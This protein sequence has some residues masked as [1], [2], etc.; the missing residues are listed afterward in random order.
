MDFDSDPHAVLFFR[1]SCVGCTTAKLTFTKRRKITFKVAVNDI[2][3]SASF[4]V[5]NSMGVPLKVLGWG[6]FHA[7]F[8]KGQLAGKCHLLLYKLLFFFLSV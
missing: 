7:V 4:F 3:L 1:H 8:Y 6:G 5:R 2:S